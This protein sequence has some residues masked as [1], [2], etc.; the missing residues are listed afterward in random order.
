MWCFREAGKSLGRDL[1]KIFIAIDDTDNRESIGT[2]RLTRML[3]EEMACRG[4]IAQGRVTRHQLLVHPDI[5]YTSHN[6][7]ACIDAEMIGAELHELA[8][9]AVS[10]LENHFH[11]G[12]NP[13]LC[14]ACRDAVPPVLFSFGYRAQR[15]VIPLD[16]AKRL[17]EELD[18]FTWFGGETGQGCIGA[19]SAVG[20]RSTNNDGRYIGLEGI[21]EIR[22]MMTAGEIISRTAIDRIVTLAGDILS[23]EEIVDTQDWIRP[24]LKQG[25]VTL[26]VI[27]VNGHWRAPH[28]KTSKK[29]KQ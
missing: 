11:E 19:M 6:S 12:A 14:I 17:T 10:F 8:R 2:G 4:M 28:K 9:Y 16:E 3:A 29:R 27:P 20:L 1:V 25:L 5:P 21:R 18:A 24:V 7:S 26:E 13:G 23:D 22:G 15:E